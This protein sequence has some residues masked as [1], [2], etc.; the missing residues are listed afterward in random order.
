M[1]TKPKSNPLPDDWVAYLTPFADAIG[2]TV[3]DASDALTPVVGAPSAEAIALLSDS[4]A[5][6]TD[7][8]ITAAFPGVPSAKLRKAIRE[9]LRAAAAPADTTAPSMSLDVL[10]SPRPDDSFLA[11]LK[12]GGVSKVG[13]TDLEAGVKAA[14]A[15][16][17]D[18]FG[19]PKK[20]IA[21][22]EAQAD[23]VEEPLGDAYYNIVKLV[24]KRDHAEVFAALGVPAS[25]VSQSKRKRFLERIDTI[26]WPAIQGFH[27]Q[28]NGWFDAWMKAAGNPAMMMQALTSMAGGGQMLAPAMAVPDTEPLRIAADEVVDTI[29]RAFA[30]VGIP[31]AR[32]LAY[33]ATEI[34]D[35]L[36]KPEIIG[37]VGATTREQMLK[38]LDIDISANFVSLEYSIVKFVLSVA[39]LSKQAKGSAHEQ[40][41]LNGLYQLGAAIPWDKLS[42]A[43]EH[44]V[45]PR[46]GVNDGR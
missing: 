6:A 12:V 27:S 35:L 40:A 4:L 15:G 5:G 10:P 21:A 22:M 25:A 23:T 8:E 14:L 7:G 43:N 9:Q 36:G 17:V 24:T 28:L 38:Q 32:A 34:K 45:A 37:L 26:L 13:M 20:L 31:A 3:A 46:Y 1:T 11:A 39:D 2:V 30:G 19:I 42:T 16:R 41:Y 44:S 29:N 33:E 18:F